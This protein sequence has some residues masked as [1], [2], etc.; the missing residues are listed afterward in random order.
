MAKSSRATIIEE[1][2][3]VLEA[4]RPQTV[5]QICYA[6]AANKVIK[7]TVA[8]F[9][10]ID[11]AIADASR[12]GQI[13]WEWI[14][15]GARRQRQ[16][17]VWTNLAEFAEVAH[18]TYNF[19]VWASQP[20]R[21]EVWIERPAL[22]GM[23][24]DALARYGIN[25]NVGQGRAVGDA[26]DRFGD[27]TAVTVLHFGDLDPTGVD[28]VQSLHERF[29]YFGSNP[30]IIKV[31]LTADD[32]GRFNLPP[33]FTKSTKRNGDVSVELEAL[34]A[35]I[36]RDRILREVK[37]RMNLDELAA[38]RAVEFLQRERLVSALRDVS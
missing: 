6:L 5:N 25:L 29:A 9:E 17:S 32:V 37:A 28:A 30:E 34:P 31:A 15:D 12:K 36:L 13:P 26:A 27:G 2:R 14:E 20:V 33:D 35:P 16:V 4:Y 23:F 38:A 21:I 22:C 24:E 7:N 10:A 11:K 18:Y 19:N 1:T 8:Q 3:S